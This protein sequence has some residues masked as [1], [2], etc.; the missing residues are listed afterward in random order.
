MAR[1]EK[2]FRTCRRDFHSAPLPIPKKCLSDK[3]GSDPVFARL[4]RP[5]FLDKEI[6]VTEIQRRYK[7]FTFASQI[8]L[9]RFTICEMGLKHIIRDD[10]VLINQAYR[11]AATISLPGFVK[12][13]SMAKDATSYPLVRM[14]G[15]RRHISRIKYLAS[16]PNHN[17]IFSGQSDLSIG[18]PAVRSASAVRLSSYLRLSA[19]LWVL[20]NPAI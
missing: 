18:N 9:E 19:G 11:E 12:L 10:G 14:R 2:P 7:H 16:P 15:G 1:F 4:G 6:D 17:L 3:L 20:N 5:A 13:Q 8:S